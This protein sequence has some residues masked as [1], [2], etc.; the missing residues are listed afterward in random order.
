MTSRSS[1]RK[2][3]CPGALRPMQ[4]GDGLI[5]RVRPRVGTLRLADLLTIAK[6]AA[7]FGSGEIDLTNRGNL[8]LRGLT[9][10]SH[11]QALAA[12]SETGLIDADEGAEAIRNII[13]DPLSGV[14][15]ARADVRP[16]AAA[17]EEI[18][19][20]NSMFWQLPAKFGWSFSGTRDARVGDRATDIMVSSIAPDTYAVLL[21]GAA[22]KGV[23]LPSN[24]VVEAV[25]RLAA[26]FLELRIR[27]QSIARMKDAVARSGS[28]MIYAAAGLEPEMLL[29]AA[30]DVIPLPLVGAHKH[31]GEIFAVGVG[32]PFGR[33]DAHQLQALCAAAS[34]AG[35]GV[36]RM[37]PQRVLVFP[38][39]DDTQ[40]YEIL[41]EAERLGLIT[42]PDDPRLFFDVCPGSRGCANATTDTRQDARRLADRLRSQ[43]LL[44]SVHVSGCEKGCARRGAAALTLVARDGR[45]D[46]I[47]DDGPAGRVA[48][49][50]VS[51]AD[52]ESAVARYL[53]EH[54]R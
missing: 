2:G 17:L 24:H 3:W 35:A 15:P 18:L 43:A 36:V 28:A 53:I 51:S 22:D 9:T 47:C 39:A 30:S 1:L 6:V 11:S 48:L 52:I 21:D 29:A 54:A 4:S 41:T 31:S 23:R 38:V 12:L 34:Q 25:T 26:V 16:L 46:L 45:Y 50:A 32:L 5:L 27:D 20:T 13:V 49:A 19:L 10:A 14:D 42:E 44:P 33:I 7:E 40:G 8:Q 37:S